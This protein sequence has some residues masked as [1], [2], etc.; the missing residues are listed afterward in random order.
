VAKTTGFLEQKRE[1]VPHRPIEERVRDF[2]E[3]DLPLPLDRLMAQASRCMDC[4][5]P[6]CHG[7][8]CP[9]AN[10][11]PEW[12]DLV[13]RGRWREACENLHATNNFPEITGRVC[14]APCEAACT[15]NINDHPVLIKHIE[16]QIAQR[17][18]EE[19]WIVPLRPRQR[20]GQRVAVIGSGPAG[21]A[22]AQQLAR[23]GHDVTVFD[24]DARAGGILR[25]GIPDFKLDKRVIDR[26]LGQLAAEGVEFQ[27][28]VTVGQDVSARY[29]RRMFDATCLTIGA[30]AARDL[31]V[32]GRGYE[33]IHLAMGYLTQQ[34]RM[35]AGEIGPQEELI[36]ARDKV[37]AVI[38]GG[39]TGS[40]CVGTARRQGA[41]QVHQLEILPQPPEATNP[42]T[43][44]PN[45]PLIM[46][47]SSS[48]EEGCT[49][50]WGVMTKRFGGVGVRVSQLHAVQVDWSSGSPQEVPGSDFVLNVDLVLLAMGFVHATHT[51][52][53]QQLGMDLDSRGNVAVSQD[54]V[55]SQPGVFAAGDAASGASLVVRSIDAGRLA[56]A[57]IDRWLRR[58]FRD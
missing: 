56:A 51:G 19:G 45:W 3:I 40:D 38:G 31:H 2:G 53:V 41:G 9:L 57:G 39:D 22:A 17:G 18:W 8:G 15:L 10:R 37:V 30:G 54:F 36:T 43:P 46:R 11:I 29:L 7:I 20:T 32:P 49:R 33:N 24:R 44:W 35:L 58:Q 55:T 13:Y 12:N 27:M 16:L 1:D 5:V 42:A 50:R 34:N 21:L 14:P 25:Y 4:G 6:F 52:L 23:A 26:R 28:G 47:T 48:H